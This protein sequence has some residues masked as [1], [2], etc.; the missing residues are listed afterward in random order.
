MKDKKKIN[1]G[2]VIFSIIVLFTIFSVS[3]IIGFANTD[4]DKVAINTAKI[5]KI[6][7]GVNNFTNDGL[8]YSNSESFSK[9]DGFIMGNDSNSDNRIIRSFDK[10]VYHFSFSITGK[11]DNNDYDDRTINIKTILPDEVK[12][13]IAFTSN[14]K[15][16][17]KE[18]TFSFS[19]ISSYFGEEYDA[20]VT[21]YVL[22]APSNLKID[23]TFEIQE[24]TNTNSEYVV[25]LGKNNDKH[26]YEYEKEDNIYSET[27][28]VS[29]YLPSVVSSKKV[30]ANLDVISQTYEGQKNKINGVNGRYITYVIGLSISGDGNGLTGYTMPNNS[31]V[32]FNYNISQDSSKD[33]IIPD[34]SFIRL[35][36]TKQV[37]DIENVELSMPYSDENTDYSRSIR[38]PG[39]ISLNNNQGTIS[40]FNVT[41]DSVNVT[42]NNEEINN[43]KY[44][45]TYA[46]TVFS[47]RDEDEV[48]DINV[49][50][51]LSNGQLKDTNNETITMSSK[52]AS[53]V[54]EYYGIY[55]YDLMTEFLDENNNAIATAHGLGS[56]SKGSTVR[57]QTN[58][59]YKNTA[60]NQ[61][62]KEVIKID[63]DAFRVVPINNDDI[64]IITNSDS[65][66]K[67]DFEIKFVTGSFD[68]D[69]YELSTISDRLNSSDKSIAT[70]TCNYNLN[71]L[72]KDEIMNLYGGPCIKAK[73]DI[74][75]AF[76]NI[77]DAKNANN[78]EIPITKIIIQ[79][80]E[81]V[82]LP[83]ETNITINAALR[84][85]NVMD[86]TKT[87]QVT[88]VASSSDYDSVLTYYS[89]RI[90]NFNDSITNKNNYTKTVYQNSQ[91]TQVD[92]NYYGDCLKIVNFKAESSITVTNKNTDG[93]IKSNFNVNKNETINYLVKTNVSDNN[94]EVGADDVWYIKN[95]VVKV[96]LPEE[97]NYVDGSANIEPEVL[98][99]RI[100]DRNITYLYFYLPYTKPNMNIS[101]I[102]FKTTLIPNL[103][104]TG[105]E[106]NVISETVAKNINDEVDNSFITELRSNFVIYATGMNNV[107]VNQ[108]LGEQGSNIEK[109]KEFSYLL[110]A[111]NNT[112]ENIDNYQIID[113]LPKNGVDSSIIDGTYKVKVTLPASLSRAK[114][115][116]STKND[117][118][119][120]IDNSQNEFKECNIT[121]DYVD[122][123]AIKITN[124]SINSYEY[125]NDI[126]LTIKP[127]NNA[128]DNKYVNS[129]IGGSREYPEN[130]SNKIEVNVISRK[131][132]GKVF[133]DINEN[134]IYDKGD[135]L[136]ENL[137]VTLYQIKNDSLTKLLET[138]T[139]KEG[140]YEFKN[141]EIGRYKV[142]I[143]YDSALYD[144][145]L[146]YGIEDMAVD[147]D[148][149]KIQEGIAEISGKYTP[150]ET[151]GIVLS[152]NITSMEN[153]DLGLIGKREFY[154]DITKY[155]TKVDLN[156][157]NLITSY[158]Y[159]NEVKVKIDVRNSLNATAKV[160]YGMTITNNSGKPGYVKIVEEN[161]P[162]G[163]IFDQDDIYNAGWF[164]TNG[165]LQNISL[166]NDIIYPGETRYLKIALTMPRQE[167]GKTFLNTVSLVSLQE[168]IKEPLPSE[169]KTI[170]DNKY[171]VGEEVNYANVNWHVVSVSDLEDGQ[172]LTLLA[173]SGTISE[174]RSHTSNISDVYKWSTSEINYY[175]NDIYLPKTLLN[176]TTL[177]D[178][179]I[180]D[181]ASGL[182]VASYGGTLESDGTCQSN[183]YTKSKIRLLTE[184]EFTN[185]A[186]T[187]SDVS[188][189]YG[190]KDYYLQ[191]SV[192]VNQEHN[193]YGQITDETNV[194][195]YAKYVSKNQTTIKSGN[196]S[197]QKEVRPVIEINSKY[198]LQN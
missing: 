196:S 138:T 107:I 71:N 50:I 80:K 104:G 30:S 169:A 78:E 60:S 155:I 66:S 115:Y 129:F 10:L 37:N 170:N 31:D 178:N 81:G 171:V 38:Y 136:L 53:A 41:Y 69:N 109:N 112:S 8:D 32:T 166:E 57:Y 148:G 35:Y 130:E 149:Y 164:M 98:K 174:K 188:W 33:A 59:S 119:K 74:E 16:G 48:D 147:S 89:P 82:I 83:S 156:Y 145:T 105:V 79:T 103:R 137:P 180:C 195:N 11:D 158:D 102:T 34:N 75:N 7:T 150:E 192:F 161:I 157:N 128:A 154:M 160:Y 135:L 151:E 126:I 97:L 62:L 120:E 153:M 165:V 39:T 133:T 63:T 40:D 99:T 181:D 106:V 54:N 5:T 123:T 185:L 76:N 6:E 131:I 68:S 94:I 9:G 36:N 134:A 184:K 88:T 197:S 159:N 77:M 70:N 163:M 1:K 93:S 58:F 144:L 146:R 56:A 46:V 140:R 118:Q 18:H 45:G 168:Y 189:L 49:S 182:M 65:L 14:D 193:S 186:N 92:W 162:D 114:V 42:A 73:N 183:I 141:L 44:I 111:Y 121:A 187:L 13:Y 142:R 21:L 124:I 101:D 4:D 179:V 3:I 91:N 117:V 72:N 172:K 43:K 108:K 167:E 143:N 198:I 95:L 90:T 139:D 52:S 177:Y 100:N 25:T 15:A 113:V 122:A 173:D 127:N 28:T 12:D 51:E 29:N 190:T 87:Y 47:Q 26:N 84:I 64:E 23:P 152:K 20:V 55:D 2:I 19:N 85:R 17:E 110:S 27:S 67:D 125:M 191:N 194:S 22:G 176:S 86:L 132:S 96:T 175:L 116:C 24:S 61:G